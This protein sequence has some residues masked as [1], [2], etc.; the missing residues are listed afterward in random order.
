LADVNLMLRLSELT[1]TEVTWARRGQQP[2]HA[3]VRATDPAIYQCPF[4]FASDVGTAGL[5]P[6]EVAGLRDYLLKGGFLWVDDFWGPLALRNWLFEITEVLPDAE[7]VPLSIDHPIFSTFY[8]VEE[9]P[10]IPSI[11]FWRQSGGGVSE[12]GAASTPTEFYGI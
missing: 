8:F 1:K 2:S 12:R 7:V 9:K 6:Q 5:S 4:L 3:V 11:Q 10:Q